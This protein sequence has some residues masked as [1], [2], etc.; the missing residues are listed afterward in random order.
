MNGTRDELRGA[1]PDIDALVAQWADRL[2]V[3]VKRVQIRSMRSK[4]GSISTA[5][6]LTLADDI[7][8]LPPDL[9]EYIVVHELMHLRYPDHRRGWRVSMGMVLPDWR[10][11]DFRL[12]NFQ[13]VS[14]T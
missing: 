12:R 6:V 4:W 2:H 3:Q 1:K 7:L 9:A 14:T 10:E 5:G 8:R 11:R 13:T